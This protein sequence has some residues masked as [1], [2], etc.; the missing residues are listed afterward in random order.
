MLVNDHPVFKDT[1]TIK[2]DVVHVSC[3]YGTFSVKKCLLSIPCYETSAASW[4]EFL[5]NSK[6]S[7]GQEYSHLFVKHTEIFYR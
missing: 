1:G 5:T 4:R 2:L 3:V 7:S 6:Q